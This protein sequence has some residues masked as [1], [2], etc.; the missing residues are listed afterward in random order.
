MTE[1]EEPQI[2]PQGQPVPPPVDPP[3]DESPTEPPAE[4]D[5]P[6]ES[7]YWPPD[8]GSAPVPGTAPYLLTKAVNLAQ[9]QQEVSDASDGIDVGAYIIGPYPDGTTIL[10]LNPSSLDP[11]VVAQAIEDHELNSDW[12]IPQVYRDFQTVMTKLAQNPESELSTDEVRSL[13]VGLA[14]QSQVPTGSVSYPFPG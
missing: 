13:A 1:S 4:P 11:D 3:P 12:G 5:A 14:L 6:E 9:L 8:P 7:P 10:W 2:D